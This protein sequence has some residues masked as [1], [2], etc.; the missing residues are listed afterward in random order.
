MKQLVLSQTQYESWQ[1]AA[2]LLFV[3]LF[4]AMLAYVWRPGGKSRAEERAQ[5]VF[6]DG[7]EAGALGGVGGAH[8]EGTR[9]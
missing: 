2:T 9:R 7:S 8:L 1:L 3:L 6:D 5:L 4:V